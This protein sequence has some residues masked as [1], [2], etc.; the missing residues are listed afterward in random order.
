MF[1]YRDMTFCSHYLIC[2]HGV[3]C[4]RA[5]PPDVKEESKKLCLPICQFANQPDCFE[6]L[7]EKPNKGDGS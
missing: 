7:W 5:L 1:C 4:E 6:A 2:K 3:T